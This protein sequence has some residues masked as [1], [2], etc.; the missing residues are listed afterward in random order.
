M[1]Q[2]LP[3]IKHVYQ[4]HT[5]DSTRW[6]RYKPRED[7]IV[8][9]TPYKCGTTWTQNIILHLIFQ[10]LQPRDIG[11][12]SPWLDMRLTALDEII[13]QLEAQKHRRCIKTHLPLDGIPY[14]PQ[15]KYVVVGRDARDVFMSMWNHYS[16][17]TPAVYSDSNNAPGRIGDPLP[18]CPE[19]IRDFW[20][21]WISRGWF[22]WETEGYPFWTNLRHTQTW[23]DYRH[24]PNIL[25]VHYN[26]LL[27]NLH[28][29]IRRI[30][31]HLNIQLSEALL[32]SIADAVK[33][34][35]M[36]QNAEQLV[37]F[38]QTIFKGGPQTF[39]NKGTNGRWREVL[40]E[41][42]LRLYEAAAARELATECAIWLEKGRLAG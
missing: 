20:Q 21:G 23:W 42:D 15:V 35:S 39:I 13:N 28:G 18:N 27:Q 7:D 14:F 22:E 38:T 30:A 26:D 40:T 37:P 5:L 17:Y 16:N 36:K 9:A 12:F 41:D 11:T 34:S 31:N 1:T 8:V 2:S 4:N 6:E 29:E 10:D 24:L 32:A 33:F 3:E 19:N 25:L